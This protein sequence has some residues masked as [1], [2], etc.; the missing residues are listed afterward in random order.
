[1]RALGVEPLEDDPPPGEFREPDAVAI[2]IREQEVGRRLTQ[3]GPDV[4][5]EVLEASSDTATLR[6]TPRDGEPEEIYQS[7]AV[8]EAYLGG[9]SALD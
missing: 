7:K 4:V 9:G 5:L 3:P 2:Q 1:M 8:Q 6:L